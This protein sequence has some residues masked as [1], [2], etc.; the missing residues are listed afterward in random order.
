MMA[1]T[2]FIAGNAF[3][4]A[5][6]NFGHI[7]QNPLGTTPV[8]FDHLLAALAVMAMLHYFVNGFYDFDHLRA[9]NATADSE[10][11]ARWL[12]VDLVVVSGSRRSPPAVIYAA[13]TRLGLALCTVQL[14]GDRGHFLDL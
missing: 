1:V 8:R 3:Y 10:I 9:R 12:F 6:G 4:L 14:A 2:V 7:G 5:L 13:L 11:L